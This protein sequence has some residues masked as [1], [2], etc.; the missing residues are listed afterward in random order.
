M[1]QRDSALGDGVR[2]HLPCV[3]ELVKLLMHRAGKTSARRKKDKD[4]AHTRLSPQKRKES[5]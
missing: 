2:K 1:P 3:D 4:H 5:Q